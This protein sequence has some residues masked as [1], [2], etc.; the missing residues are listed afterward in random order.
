MSIE[1]GIIILNYKT[2]QLCQDCLDSLA[3]EVEPAVSVVVVDNDSGDGSADKIEQHI[4]ARGFGAWARVLRSPVN[5]G[6]AA[7]N[8]LGIRSMDAQAYLLLNSDTLVKKGA[9][10][11]FRRALREHPDA[12]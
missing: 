2:A 8:N 3:S 11:A 1:L 9:L 10:A 7:G 4:A 5:G 12:G 6:F